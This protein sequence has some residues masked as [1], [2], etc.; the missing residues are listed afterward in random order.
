MKKWIKKA[1]FGLVEWAG[2]ARRNGRLAGLGLARCS[3]GLVW[4]DI[5][6]MARYSRGLA[7][8]DGLGWA[9]FSRGLV[10][11]DNLGRARFSRGLAG[12]E[13]LENPEIPEPLAELAR[14]GWARKAGAFWLMGLVMMIGLAGCSGGD[15]LSEEALEAALEAGL[16][17]CL[18]FGL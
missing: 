18:L 5:L 3:R 14:L 1:V 8:L 6:G 9:R 12:L 13:N 17:T 11:L 15:F 10:G 4:L 16:E 7:R 2:K